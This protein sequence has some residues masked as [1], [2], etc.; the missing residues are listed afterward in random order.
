MKKSPQQGSSLLLILWAVVIVSAVIVVVT[1]FIS[2]EL[3]ETLLLTKD[4]EARHLAETGL[5]YARHP[6]VKKTSPLLKKEISPTERYEASVHSEGAR[7]NLNFFA[8]RQ[9][10]E[11]FRKVLE[12][13][14]LNSDQAETLTDCILD[15]VDS[16]DLTRLHGAERSEY[17]AMGLPMFPFNRPF[18]S[19]AEVH[20][21][22]GIDMLDAVK[23]DWED[24][25]TLDSSGP[26]NLSEA[27]PELISGVCRISLTQ[28]Q[29][30]VK[31]RQG[32]DGKDGTDDDVLP[33]SLDEVSQLLG[34]SPEKFREIQQL[35]SIDDSVIRIESTGVVGTRKITITEVVR[36][37]TG[38]LQILNRYEKITK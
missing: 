4:T 24:S 5:A 15:W 22:S 11:T 31:H 38:S 3:D 28:A 10:V 17:T 7:L 18:Q 1:R 35:V 13:W 8:K 27:P 36:R 33:T 6:L 32:P 30:F 16:D 26:L 21:V 12:N 2:Q 37:G 25:V 9:D 23:P 14:G 34:L 20:L 19:L 29:A